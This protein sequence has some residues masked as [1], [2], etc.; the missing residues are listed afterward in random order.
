MTE[1]KAAKASTYMEKNQGEPSVIVQKSDNSKTI[2]SRT[3]ISEEI[4]EKTKR[5]GSM[6]QNIAS[7]NSMKMFSPVTIAYL[8]CLV[9]MSGHS[10]FKRG[11]R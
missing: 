4:I 5:L 11:E 9:M 3:M 6:K 7:D 2:F 8:I 1:E 10:H